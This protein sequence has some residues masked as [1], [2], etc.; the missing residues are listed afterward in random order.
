MGG[1]AYATISPVLSSYI[2]RMTALK[3][4]L[5]KPMGQ[6]NIVKGDMVF[7][8]G[9]KEKGK[10]GIVKEVTR[11]KNA[12][13]VEGLNLVKKHVK[14]TPE[15]KGGIFTKEMPIHYSNLQLIDPVQDKPTRIKKGYVGDSKTKSRI[16]KLSGATVW[17][18]HS[19]SILGES[20]TW[21]YLNRKELLYQNLRGCQ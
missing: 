8:N 21:N 20:V 16:S 10:R 4:R 19:L 18:S 6:Y 12:V 7:V 5:V 17:H 11:K 1:Y 9:G 14:S 2:R 13:I 3:K 15:H